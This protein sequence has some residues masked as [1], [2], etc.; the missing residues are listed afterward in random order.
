MARPGGGTDHSTDFCEVDSIN[1]VEGAESVRIDVEH[2]Y[3]VI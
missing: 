1:F 2:A 3:E